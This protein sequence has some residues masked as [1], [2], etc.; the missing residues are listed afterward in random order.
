MMVNY[1]IGENSKFQACQ[2]TNVRKW[3][4]NLAMAPGNLDLNISQSP[5]ARVEKMGEEGWHLE[6]PA[7]AKRGYR[8]AQL[9]DH[10][11]LSRR[12]FPWEP[13]L[14]FSLQARISALE[15]P[16]TWGFGLW[17]DPFSFLLAYNRVVPRFPVLPDAAWFFHA[18]PQNYLSFRDDLPASG[19]LAATFSSQKV[20]FALLALASPALALTLI[21]NTAQ[22]VRRLLRRAI[23]QDASLIH[24]NVTEWHEYSMEW[25]VGQVRF[26]LDGTDILQT[27]ITPIGPLSLVIWVDNQYAA[28]PPGGRVRYGTLPNPEPAWMEIRG[29]SIQEKSQVGNG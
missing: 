15:I 25:D 13:S 9:D 14:K 7:N 12:N 5:T 17:N 24:T 6:I 2:F 4:D 8:L 19:F 1:I 16:G 26:S 20:P 3:Y 23:R 21:P 11:S 18:S 29:V 27:D 28:L 22:M 10:E